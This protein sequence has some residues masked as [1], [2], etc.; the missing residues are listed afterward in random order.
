M[1]HNCDAYERSAISTVLI[2]CGCLCIS[3]PAA[4]PSIRVG[5]AFNFFRH[6]QPVS[7]I[8]DFQPAVLDNGDQMESVQSCARLRR[9]PWK[10][11]QSHFGIAL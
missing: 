11:P 3:A 8:T 10:P 7:A 4:S 5:G 6:K 2:V 1:T 9:R